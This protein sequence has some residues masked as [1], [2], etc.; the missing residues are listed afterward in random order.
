MSNSADLLSHY[1]TQENHME[2]FS[3]L[4]KEEAIFY[5]PD[6]YQIGTKHP[7]QGLSLMFVSWRMSHVF[8]I[9]NKNG[10]ES[11]GPKKL[12]KN[13]QYKN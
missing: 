7:S 8:V 6:L 2:F 10:L 9:I 3:T 1:V 5:V 4:C 11:L 13:Y 12:E